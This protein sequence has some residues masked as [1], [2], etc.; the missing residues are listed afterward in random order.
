MAVQLIEDEH[1][2]RAIDTYHR[3]IYSLHEDDYAHWDGVLVRK[4]PMDLWVYAELIHRIK[5]DVIIETGTAKGGSALFFSAMQRM[6][7]PDGLVVTIDEKEPP[8]AL[9]HN[10]DGLHGI[11]CVEGRSQD[12]AVFKLAKS[13]IADGDTVFVSLDAGHL[14]Q[15][16]YSEL[17]FYAPLVTPG[18]YCV[19]EDTNIEGNP[20]GH[21]GVQGPGR[22]IDRYLA[23]TDLAWERDRSCERFM[24]TFNPG[25]WLKRL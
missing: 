6:V 21:A 3:L 12:P 22:A 2:Q 10:A 16:V 5:P 17:L 11:T 23:E 18:S 15:E 20:I 7:K 14:T 19:V 1:D 8:D 13:F 24:V 25:G 9:A 4:T